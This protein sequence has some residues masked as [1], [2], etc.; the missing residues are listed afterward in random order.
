MRTIPEKYS[1]IVRLWTYG[2][3]R[4]LENLRVFRG[5][6]LFGRRESEFGT[7]VRAE[8]LVALDGVGRFVYSHS[9]KEKEWGVG[10]EVGGDSP[11]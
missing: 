8:V 9:R 2:F 1:I 4:L 7:R 6:G 11:G 5:L 10:G 3:H